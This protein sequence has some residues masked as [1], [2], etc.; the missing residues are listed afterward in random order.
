[1]SV[2][3]EPLGNAA[4]FTW[5]GTGDYTEPSGNSADFTWQDTGARILVA[6]S[7]SPL[8]V[9]QALAVR[10]L[11]AGRSTSPLTNGQALV[12]RPPGVSGRSAGP[13]TPGSAVLRLPLVG[14]VVSDYSRIRKLGERYFFP[15]VPPIQLLCPP[16]YVHLEGPIT[17]PEDYATYPFVMDGRV[18][19]VYWGTLH[20][21]A[22]PPELRNQSPRDPDGWRWYGPGRE[23]LRLAVKAGTN[24]LTVSVKFDLNTQ[25]RPTLRLLG[26]SAL[27]FAEQVVEAPAGT[28]SFH[29]LTLSFSSLASGVAA[30]QIEW[31]LIQR[32]ATCVWKSFTITN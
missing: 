10:L 24:V 28:G 9:G 21:S 17:Y 27:G 31:W 8:T 13:L 19:Q 15:A 14:N 4:D 20:D 23:V 5:E 18:G 11:A 12:S 25:P 6:R 7:A 22:L 26:S 1:M 29:D 32:G 30:I 2:Y 3:T 16:P